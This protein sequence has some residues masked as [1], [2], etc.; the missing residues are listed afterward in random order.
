ML[1]RN[2]SK[3]ARVSY[4]QLAAR[5]DCGLARV[6]VAAVSTACVSSVSSQ[7]FSPNNTFHH[8]VIVNV[9]L[10]FPPS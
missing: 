6:T 1:D 7:Y 3:N 5:T 8:F 10:Y 2:C 9:D 4:F